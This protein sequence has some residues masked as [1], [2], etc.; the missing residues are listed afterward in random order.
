MNRKKAI[1]GGSTSPIR[2]LLVD[3]SPA[4]LRLLVQ[5]LGREDYKITVAL[6]GRQA[7]ERALSEARPDLIVLD[8][9]MPVLSGYGACTLLK[10]NPLTA[11]IPIIFVTASTDLKDRLVGFGLGGA[12]YVSKPYDAAELTARIRAHVGR[13]GRGAAAHGTPAWGSYHADNEEDAGARGS[14]PE[15]DA[16]AGWPAPTRDRL[17][18]AAS[19][20]YLSEHLT[21]PPSQKQLAKQMGVNEKRINMAFRE[22][23]GLSVADFVHNERM[24]RAKQM[25]LD[26]ALTIAEIGERLGFSS[27]ANFASAFRRRVGYPPGQFRRHA[28]TRSSLTTAQ[29]V[30]QGPMEKQQ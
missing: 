14:P 29:N 6:N 26:P 9:S 7:Y 1:S 10:R 30:F 20:R 27:A 11:Q 23:L 16:G 15:A 28:T 17:I 13:S 5:M 18:V 3:D 24:A 4:D 2:L 22:F 21:S 8:V 25:L 12:D 19:V